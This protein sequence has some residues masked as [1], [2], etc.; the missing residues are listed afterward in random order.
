VFV[1]QRVRTV[2]GMVSQFVKVRVALGV[3]KCIGPCLSKPERAAI[4]ASEHDAIRRSVISRRMLDVKLIDPA[5]IHV[6]AETAVISVDNVQSTGILMRNQ[7]IIF[8]VISTNL[9]LDVVMTGR[10]NI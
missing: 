9:E 7:E 6:G 1:G 4:A 5:E 3:T 2:A 8:V 10:T